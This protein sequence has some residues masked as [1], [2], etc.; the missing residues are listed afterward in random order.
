[1]VLAVRPRPRARI[2]LQQRLQFRLRRKLAGDGEQAYI[3]PRARTI[4]WSNPSSSSALRPSSPRR[5]RSQSPFLRTALLTSSPGRRSAVAP[6]SGYGCRRVH[7]ESPTH[8]PISDRRHRR[9]IAFDP[10]TNLRKVTIYQFFPGS[11]RILGRIST[12]LL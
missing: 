12:A 9:T 5:D 7:G 10:S 3:H 1:M 8:D 11:G 4:T 2:R 6:T